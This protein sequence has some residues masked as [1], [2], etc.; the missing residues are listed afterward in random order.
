MKTV[1]KFNGK[2]KVYHEKSRKQKKENPTSPSSFTRL[3]TR[4]RSFKKAVKARPK[5]LNKQIEVVKSLASK[6]D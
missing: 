5:S 2:K 4:K 3:S 6:F 1:W